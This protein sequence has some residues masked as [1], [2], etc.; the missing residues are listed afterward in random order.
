[1]E[2]SDE[3]RV[4]WRYLRN[5]LIE[6]LGRFETGAIQMRHEGANVSTDAIWELKKSIEDFDRLISESEAGEA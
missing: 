1:M 4:R 5:L 2:T 6:Q 3:L